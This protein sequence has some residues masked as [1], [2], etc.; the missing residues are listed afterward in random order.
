MK[1]QYYYLVSSLPMLEFG[2]N[3]PFLYKDFLLL[4]KEQLLPLDMEAIER[5]SILPTEDIE[6]PSPTLREW[7]KFDITLRNELVKSRSHKHGKDPIQYM[8]GDYQDPFISH[9]T[10]YLVTE[11]SPLE[12]E[13]SLDRKRWEKIE[14]LKNGH[15]F[16]IDCLTSYA[17]QL[18]ILQRWNRINSSGG[19]EILQSLVQKG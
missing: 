1:E 4:C 2:M 14:E 9:F 11:G 7:K 19:M 10:Q 12:R 18:Q 13:S 5:A 6:D 15:Y 16:D 17:L 8:R 3:A